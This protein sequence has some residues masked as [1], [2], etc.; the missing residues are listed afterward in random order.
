LLTFALAAAGPGACAQTIA[1]PSVSASLAFPDPW[2]VVTPASLPVYQAM[3]D[4]AGLNAGIMARRFASDGVAAEGYSEDFGDSFRLLV[5]QDAR[6]ERIFDIDRS[7]AAQRKA[8]LLSYTDTRQ[9]R[10]TNIRYTEGEW[11]QRNGLGRVLFLRYNVLD[12]EDI[13]QRGLQ[14]LIL[15]NGHNYV[16]DWAVAGRRITNRDLSRFEERLAGLA[17]TEVLP[18][19]PL[20][21]ELALDRILPQES[22]D[23]NLRITGKT[24]PNGG[25]V[26]SHTRYEGDPPVVLS[27]G[28]AGQDGSFTLRCT[29]PAQGVYMLTLTAT[30]EGCLDTE[31]QQM[32]TYQQGLLPVNFDALPGPAFGADE[33]I[34]AGWTLAGA[35]VQLLDGRAGQQKKA[36]KDGRFSFKVATAQPGEYN[37]TLSVTKKDAK[38]RRI[39]ITFTRE[40]TASHDAQDIREEAE[41]APYGDLVQNPGDYVG[42]LLTFTGTVTQISEGTGVWFVRLNVAPGRRDA[43]RPLVLL[44]DAEP[45]AELAEGARVTC[46]A[47]ANSPFVEQDAQGAEVTVP[48]LTNR[49]LDIL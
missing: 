20:P 42:R 41:Q 49:W 9:W 48:S 17:F 31:V 37:L 1:L 11:R 14:Y 40:R 4:E 23:G 13:A 12:G 19:P 32:L 25:V 26:L 30:K 35:Q 5:T 2:L 21:A 33:F 29:L 45:P 34:L 27:V 16:L 15:R 38:E 7:T 18:P 6:S 3:L 39:P 22:G 47:Q 24:E 8:I 43:P 10:L 46:Y 36:G 44:F 28:T